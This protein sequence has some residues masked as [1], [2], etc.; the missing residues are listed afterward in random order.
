VTGASNVS[1]AMA[2]GKQAARAIDEQL[3][4]AQRWESLFPE[5]KYDQTLPK[6]VSEC[7][8]QHSR[9]LSLRERMQSSAEVVLGLPAEE[10][11][12]EACRCLRC[13]IK[14]AASR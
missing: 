7:H 14:V 8:R 5:T 1:N 12:E 6:D 13:D 9:E 10:A 3:M 4:D 11:H 2:L